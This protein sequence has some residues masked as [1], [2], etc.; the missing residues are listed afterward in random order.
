MLEA[1]VGFGLGSSCVLS[2]EQCFKGEGI[3]CA[4]ERCQNREME[5][6]D[7]YAGGRGPRSEMFLN[8]FR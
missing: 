3:K 6:T 5:G 4:V 1:N 7:E 2:S 8:A